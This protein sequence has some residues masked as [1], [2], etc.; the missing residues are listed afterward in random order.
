ML[1]VLEF[2]MRGSSKRHELVVVNGS[3]TTTAQNSLTL[4]FGEI[5]SRNPSYTTVL[6]AAKQ[7][8]IRMYLVAY[9]ANASGVA[10]SGCCYGVVHAAFTN[11]SKKENFQIDLSNHAR[12]P[13]KQA[14]ELTSFRFDVSLV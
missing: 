5:K 3:A 8:Y 9:V 13:W 11:E 4:D 2:D 1:K 14:H 12:R 10:S 6:K 7:L